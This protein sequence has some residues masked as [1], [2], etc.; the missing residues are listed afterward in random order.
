MCCMSCV[1]CQVSGIRCQVS[2]VRC[3]ASCVTWHIDIYKYIYTFFLLL[4]IGGTSRWRV[5][6]QWGLPRVVID[7]FCFHLFWLGW[8]ICKLNGKTQA[9]F[10][11]KTF[12]RVSL[13][14]LSLCGQ[15][16]ILPWTSS[17]GR[18]ELVVRDTKKLVESFWGKERNINDCRPAVPLGCEII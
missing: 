1:R 5:C 12:R 16:D 6:Y 2:G 4:S 15:N 10:R 3:Q 13:R 14:R 9:D 8:H 17:V 7:I 11:R 18:S